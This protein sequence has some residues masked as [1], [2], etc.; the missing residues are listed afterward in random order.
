MSDVA[1]Q[2]NTLHCE[3]TGGPHLVAGIASDEVHRLADQVR[4]GESEAE[5]DGLMLTNTVQKVSMTSGLSRKGKQQVLVNSCSPFLTAPS[6][7]S[8]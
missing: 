5:T 8:S 3:V 1:G 6:D 4:A 7:S 2:S